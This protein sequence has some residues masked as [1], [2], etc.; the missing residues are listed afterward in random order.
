MLALDLR[1]FQPQVDGSLLASSSRSGKRN[2]I[3][4]NGWLADSNGFA[5]KWAHADLF[6][7]RQRPVS[8]DGVFTRVEDGRELAGVDLSSES[9]NVLRLGGP[10]MRVRIATVLCH[11][12]KARVALVGCEGEDLSGV[13]PVCANRFVVAARVVSVH[14][15]LAY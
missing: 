1:A 11:R 2:A 6:E 5:E 13:G 4:R 10:P 12:E 8:G 15:E 7:A 14:A 9:R 3:V